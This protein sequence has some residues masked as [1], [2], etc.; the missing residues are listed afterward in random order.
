MPPPVHPAILSTPQYLQARAACI[1]QVQD[2]VTECTV[3]GVIT[4]WRDPDFDIA[5]DANA[6]KKC[7]YGLFEEFPYESGLSNTSR[8]VSD[9]FENPVFV[10]SYSKPQAPIQGKLGD[11]CWLFTNDETP[12]LPHFARSTDSTETWVSLLEKAFAK[13]HG[14][15]HSIDNGMTDQG[16]QDL[17]GAVATTG[18][19]NFR[20][21]DNGDPYLWQKLLRVTEVGDRL[22]GVFR[23]DHATTSD[24]EK[25]AGVATNE[26]LHQVQYNHAYT[27]LRTVE[28]QGEKFVLLRNPYGRKDEGV[29]RDFDPNWEKIGTGQEWDDFRAR[30]RKFDINDDNQFRAHWDYF[31]E[32]RL[33]GQEW[34]LATLWLRVQGATLQEE[35]TVFSFT[36]NGASPASVVISLAQLDHRYYQNL[37]FDRLEWHTLRFKLIR[38]SDNQIFHCSETRGTDL[39]SR[40]RV[41]WQES[42][43]VLSPGTYTVHLINPG[44]AHSDRF[45]KLN[46]RGTRWQYLLYGY[47]DTLPQLYMPQ[48]EIQMGR[49]MADSGQLS[50]AQADMIC[51]SAHDASNDLAVTKR[52]DIGI[53]QEFIHQ[54]YRLWRACKAKTAEA[55]KAAKDAKDSKAAEVVDE[56]DEADKVTIVVESK[57]AK[58]AIVV[59][60]KGAKIATKPDARQAAEAAE[61]AKVAEA[62]KKKAEED[63]KP[64]QDKL[65]QYALEIREAA[66][67]YVGLRIYSKRVEGTSVTLE[68]GPDVP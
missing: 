14:D 17:T 38:A 4:Q 44:L 23:P 48:E 20:R 26:L 60:P 22:F 43:G 15:Y 45:G 24:E 11:C 51:Y 39:E 52:R 41:I 68:P 19:K 56:A 10:R 30:W 3:N 8:R 36:I 54:Y 25:Q 59:E 63:L 50:P 1:Q 5:G 67:V 18:R 62:A 12:A 57:G 55:T 13:L 47:I 29:E 64:F 9:L 53:T 37:E 40:E 6:R 66:A 27:V 34:D 28:Y 32:A 31:F 35:I 42:D 49:S 7:L 21:G 58:V 46:K 61:A 2:I 33:F 65:D 16:L